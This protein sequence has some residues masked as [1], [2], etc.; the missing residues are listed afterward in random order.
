[1]EKSDSQTVKVTLKVKLLF[2][3]TSVLLFSIAL[4]TTLNYLNFEK[5]LNETS[6]STYQIVLEETHNDINQAI[7][8]GL[9]L[10]SITNIQSLLERRELLV[11]G[12]THIS[13]LSDSGKTLFTSGDVEIATANS[14][15]GERAL[16]VDILNT[17]NVKEGE[18]TLHYST[19]PLNKLKK[20]LLSKQ[21]YIAVFWLVI[22]AGLGFIA[23]KNLLDGFLLKISKAHQA[24]TPTPIEKLGE[25]QPNEKLISKEESKSTLSQI[26]KAHQ[27]VNASSSRSKWE[28]WTN[29][30]FPI[31][32]ISITVG[33]T[34]IANAGLSYQSMS[35]FSTVYE[36]KLEQKSNLIGETLSTVI[37]RLVSSGIP[38]N[39]LNGLEDEFSIYTHKHNEILSISL[40][41]GTEAIYQYPNEFDEE[42]SEHLSSLVSD[43]DTFIKVVT[44]DNLIINL[45]K[46]SFMD[47]MTVLIASCLVVI[48]IILFTCHFLI[49]APW[50]QLKQVFMAVNR[51]IV[52]HLATI[53]SKDEI[54]QLLKKLNNSVV[55][56][57]PT[58]PNKQ[59][60]ALDYRF[61]RLPLFLL[62]F[63][64]ASSLAFFPNFVSSL[65]NNQAWIPESLQTSIPISLFM[66]CWAL[67]LP[68][69]GYWSDKVGRR[70]SLIAGASLTAIG[71]ALT[72]FVPN[73]LTLLIARSI[74]AVGYGIV[75]ISAQGYVTDTTHDGNRTKGMA[76]FL[77][78]FFSG[79]LCGAAI[80]G[81]LAD[82]LGYSTT[83]LCA[84]LLALLSALL[85]MLFF[86]KS[87]SQNTSKP[88]RLS[89]FKVLLSNKYFALICLFSAI[90]AKIVLTGFLY[91]IC[92]VY[93]QY[94]GESSSVSGRIMMTYGLSL[95]VISPISAALVDKYR[96]KMVFI[97]CGGLLSAIALINILVLPG[98][99]GLLMIVIFIGVAHGICVSPQ[100]P[101]VIE[102]LRE[103]GIDKGKT[104]GIFRLLERIGNVAGPILAGF[105]LSLFGF[106][107][108]ILIFGLTLLASSIVLLSLFTLFTKTDKQQLGATR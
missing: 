102:L 16:S 40:I 19:T 39:K 44:D 97:V 24:L 58:Q 23:V 3:I 48:E 33:L 26:T 82:K 35:S 72:A 53:I 74:T 87:D 13:V 103:Q 77:S 46:E 95:I 83:F 55:K 11:D 108:T 104:I 100:I 1:M 2:A 88:V 21:V 28:K 86:T 76:T 106:E 47:M 6:D 90:P 78:A 50:Q 105:I 59:L 84:A 75:F 79:S 29:K 18:L 96:N 30:H 8:L 70:Y 45:L 85:V 38:I 42:G 73:M 4:N 7:S 71:L 65:P 68:F 49:L 5:R 62:V 31:V 54:G 89:D 60:F 12:I 41:R 98:T 93:L 17:F 92:P 52:N 66:L 69:A 80:G 99:Y 27:I 56:L 36:A 34:V 107:T 14:N 25:K 67:S 43:E 20:A 101:L 15:S 61:I 32:I 57:N 63:A 10:A 9:P 81:I 91:Y 51:D 94:L 37:D 64:E 22:T